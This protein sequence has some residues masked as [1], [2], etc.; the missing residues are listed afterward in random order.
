LPKHLLNEDWPHLVGV[1][2]CTT[3]FNS[4][5]VLSWLVVV[6]AAVVVVAAAVV[7]V[8]ATVVVVVSAAVVVVTDVRQSEIRT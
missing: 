3:Q 4:S 5:Q 8:A 2:S 7:V 6:A 1:A